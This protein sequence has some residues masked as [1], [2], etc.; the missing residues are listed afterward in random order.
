[1]TGPI[2]LLPVL[3][4]PARWEVSGQVELSEQWHAQRKF[5]I[6]EELDASCDFQHAPGKQANGQE[7][8][9][10]GKRLVLPWSIPSLTV[11]IDW[12]YC[13]TGPWVRLSVSTP[14]IWWDTATDELKH[15]PNTDDAEIPSTEQHPATETN[16]QLRLPHGAERLRSHRH[17]PAPSWAERGHVSWVSKGDT[18][19]SADSYS[20]SPS[21]QMAN[22]GRWCKL[23]TSARWRGAW[24][25]GSRFTDCYWFTITCNHMLG[26]LIESHVPVSN[27]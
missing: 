5:P 23:Q 6:N 9:K 26:A 13:I 8:T 20:L 27:R 19:R 3:R 10:Q 17:P 11:K 25:H 15:S 16:Y 18:A 2:H 22:L 1:M 24:R 4:T 21:F 14:I 12:S 7:R